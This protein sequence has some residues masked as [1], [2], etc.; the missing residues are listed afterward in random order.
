MVSHSVGLFP[1][2]TVER[3]VEFNMK[4]RNAPSDAR[5]VRAAELLTM[6][7]ATAT[8]GI[9]ASTVVKSCARFALSRSDLVLWGL[10]WRVRRG[11]QRASSEI[12]WRGGCGR[13]SARS[14][15]QAGRGYLTR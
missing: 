7:G 10:S 1:W 2:M 13:T 3:N 15:F 4:A 8:S 9:S 6:M 12:K 11:N 14:C 5:A